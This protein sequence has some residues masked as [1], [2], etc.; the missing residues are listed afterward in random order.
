[1]ASSIS[2][3]ASGGG[4]TWVSPPSG[5]D[6]GAPCPHD[7]PRGVGPGGGVGL[8]AERRA[9][10]HLAAVHGTRRPPASRGGDERLAGDP[11][12]SLQQ[13]VNGLGCRRR[14][15]AAQ[16]HGRWRRSGRAGRPAPRPAGDVIGLGRRLDDPRSERKPERAAVSP[17]A[18]LLDPGD[19]RGGQLA[20]QVLGTQRPPEGQLQAQPVC[21]GAA[22]GGRRGHRGC[23][24]PARAARSGSW[25]TPHTGGVELADALEPGRERDVG[26]RQRAGLD[27]RARQS[28]AACGSVRRG[29]QRQGRRRRRT[30]AA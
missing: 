26:H 15:R 19:H 16:R 1:M 10:R 20:E 13:A 25:R 30:Q 2:D 5:S 29:A 24:R 6:T 28:S 12:S 3:S 9:D 17:A 4:N 11:G 8:L 27:Q 7:Q 23:R 14:G 18:D 22:P 21:A